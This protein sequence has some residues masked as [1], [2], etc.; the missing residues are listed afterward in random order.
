[1]GL[2]DDESGLV[3]GVGSVAEAGVVVESGSAKVLR[4]YFVWERRNV[5]DGTDRDSH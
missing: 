1:M 3:V 5:T 4:P 2:A